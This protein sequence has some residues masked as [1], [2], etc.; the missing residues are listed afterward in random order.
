MRNEKQWIYFKIYCHPLSSDFI[1]TEYLLP[2]I[3]T[4]QKKGVLQQFFWIRYNDPGYHIRFRVRPTKE[5]YGQSF[6]MLSASLYKLH[7]IKLVSQFHTDIYKQEI[8]RYTTGL[9]VQV[10]S[11][12]QK[13]SLLAFEFL[14]RKTRLMWDDNQTLLEA[15]LSAKNILEHFDFSPPQRIAFCKAQFDLFFLEFENP[16]GLK[17]ELDKL[18]KCFEDNLNPDH[19][20]N[21]DAKN[22]TIQQDIKNL[23][24]LHKKKKI[25]NV[26]IESLAADILHMHLNR[27]FTIDQRYREMTVYY[28]LFRDFSIREFR[29][30]YDKKSTTL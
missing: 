3:E 27:L 18:Q 19:G 12:F 23:K 21:A 10:E 29:K 14:V 2:V 17:V 20:N 11:V 8:L 7:T 5:A 6:E 22:T 16:K 26:S 1:L 25:R 13:S 9:M 15:C 30:Q 4:L 28:L 24:Y